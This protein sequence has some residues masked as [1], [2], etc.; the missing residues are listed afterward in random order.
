MWVEFKEILKIWRNVMRKNNVEDLKKTD[1]HGQ[2]YFRIWMKSQGFTK[3]KKIVAKNRRDAERQQKEG[4]RFLELS[5]AHK[6]GMNK[7]CVFMSDLLLKQFSLLSLSRRGDFRAIF[8]FWTEKIGNVKIVDISPPMLSHVQHELKVEL[9]NGFLKASTY[10]KYVHFLKNTLKKAFIDWYYLPTDLSVFLRCTTV[11]NQRDRVLTKEEKDR[12]FKAANDSKEEYFVDLLH[13]LFETGLRKMEALDLK[14]KDCDFENNEISVQRAK[15]GKTRKVPMSKKVEEILRRRKEKNGED[16]I[17][18]KP[19][20]G[21]KA[22]IF[23]KHICHKAKIE[24]FVLHDIRHN[25]ASKMRRN[26]ISPEALQQILGHSSYKSLNRYLHF[27]HNFEHDKVK[28]ILN[29]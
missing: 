29:S 23:M 13:I 27:D 25:F 15:N 12:L 9:N 4:Q 17:F 1:P 8:N 6:K 3:N 19:R 18:D 24:D 26:G 16:Y 7:N 10:N 22:S 2:K 21:S 14:G 5:V 20:C 28:N 11:S